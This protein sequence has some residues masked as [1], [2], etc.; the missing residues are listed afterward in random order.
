MGLPVPRLPSI[1][2]SHAVL[3]APLERSTCPN[4]RSLLALKMKSRSS[5]SSFASSSLDLTIRWPHP[6]AWYCKSIWS[7]PYHWAG[8]SSWSVAKFHWHG[9][10]CSAPKCC[11]HG[12]GSCKRGG[13]MWELVVAPWTSSR[14]FSFKN[15]KLFFCVSLRYEMSGKLHLICM[16]T[17]GFH[18]HAKIRCNL[19]DI[20]YLIETQKNN[21]QF[22]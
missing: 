16:K 13:E 5:S 2:L 1:C 19:N 21:F 20:S 12:P 15:W 10:W 22:L 7:W 6:L 17:K 11:I 4:Q 18:V 14:L 3:T 9:A 8:G